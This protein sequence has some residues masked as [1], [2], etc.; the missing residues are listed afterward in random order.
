[1]AFL[2]FEERPLNKWIFSFFRSVYSPTV[3][4]WEKSQKPIIFFQEEASVPKDTNIIAPHGEVAL[5]EYLQTRPEEKESFLSKFEG[6][7]KSFLE[8]FSSLFAFPSK[9]TIPKPAEAPQTIQA[10]VAAKKPEGLTVPE[11][12]PVQVA[13]Q[14]FRPKII[15]E[16]KPVVQ[17]LP[18]PKS[19]EEKVAP[20]LQ[21]ESVFAKTAQFSP[22]AAPP[23]PPT[24][25]NTIAGQVVDANRKI[26]EGAI[27]EIRDLAG[28]PVRALRSNK[29]GHFT[30]VTALANGQYDL[31]TEKDGY[32]FDP[33]TFEAKGEIIPP[34][35]IKAKALVN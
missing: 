23:T 15:V 24:I 11:N 27:L 4:I 25:P 7:E 20:T 33:V 30:I 26:I 19:L 31:I 17:D 1:M 5:D 2:P 29:V 8:R 6:A 32:L 9:L 14:G 28:R 35:L 16:E 3:F 22:E 12:K 18:V 34:I 10:G 13:T 21:S